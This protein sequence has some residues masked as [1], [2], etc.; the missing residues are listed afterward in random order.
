MD[1][2]RAISTFVRVVEAGSLTAAANLMGV[3]LTSVVR[4]LANL[5]ARL[6]VR[7]LNRTTRRIALTDEGRDYFE[8]CQRIVA[9]LDDADAAVSDRRNQPSGIVRITAPVLCGRLHVAPV[10]ADFLSVHP[11][12][13]AELMMQDRVVDLLEEGLDLAV[14]IGSLDD[15]SLVAVT[16]G[17]TRRAVCASPEYLDRFGIPQIPSD[18]GLHRCID[19]TGLAPSHNWWTFEHNGKAVRIPVTAAAAT[20]QVD[21]ALVFCM[22]GLGLGMFLDYQIKA[23]VDAGRLVRVLTDF[24]RPAVPISVLYPGGRLS[25]PPRVR[26][27]LDWAV[28]RLRDRLNA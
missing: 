16:V 3:S 12:L 23:A 25:P 27:F 6:K 26:A 5:E 17:A 19:F 4:S 2:F 8:R 1:K 21:A 7:L 28:P 10:V 20:N 9:A 22:Q 24:E 11:T 13:R 18:I 14:R 15:S